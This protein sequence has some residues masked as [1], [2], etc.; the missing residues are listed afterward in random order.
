MMKVRKWLAAALLIGAAAL[1][2]AGSAEA[3]CLR[4]LCAPPC[5]PPPPQHIILKVCHPC[6]GCMHD[7]PVC[8]PACC[9]GV[10]CVHFERTLIGNGK[11]VFEWPGGHTVVVRYPQGGGVRVIQRD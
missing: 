2:S 10:P 3:F 9:K 8:I 11:T 6:T 4:S 1:A 7:V 5:P